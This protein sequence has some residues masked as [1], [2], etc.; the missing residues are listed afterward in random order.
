M[1]NELIY[2][3]AFVTLVAVAVAAVILAVRRDGR[4]AGDLIKQLIIWVGIAA[5]LPATS[6]AGATIL[7]P[8]TRL[9]DLT[10]QRERVAQDTNDTNSDVAARTKARDEQQRLDKLID[11]EQRP[12]YRAMFR[13]GY[14]I[15][16]A[17]LVV[18][19]FLRSVAVGTGLAFGGLCTLT[20]G[21]YSYWE[22][23]GDALRFFSLLAVLAILIVIGLLRRRPAVA[24][25]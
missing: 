9:R 18:G 11:E 21:C 15:G 22:A 2:V 24:A 5:L 1:D 7:H 19:L 12:F 3:A 10:S 8:R 17:A 4:G 25:D 23:M 13:V 6:W 16:L 20:V 14:P